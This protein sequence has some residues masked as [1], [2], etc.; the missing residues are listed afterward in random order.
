MNRRRHT[1]LALLATTGAIGIVVLI[2]LVNRPRVPAHVESELL[3]YAVGLDH[4][5]V[6]IEYNLT[7]STTSGPSLPSE[8]VISAQEAQYLR[9]MNDIRASLDLAAWRDR[10][11]NRVVLIIGSISRDGTVYFVGLTG[12]RQVVTSTE[13]FSGDFADIEITVKQS[14]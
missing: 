14:P 3:A 11:D 8:V 5:L 6:A 9:G 2:L 1:N 10:H 4:V 13:M 12:R 7:S